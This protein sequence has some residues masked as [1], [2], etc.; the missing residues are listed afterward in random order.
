VQN[1]ENFLIFMYIK[2]LLKNKKMTNNK[3]PKDLCILSI[4]IRK[5]STIPGINSGIDANGING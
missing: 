5:I 2:I 4:D 3:I 1:H